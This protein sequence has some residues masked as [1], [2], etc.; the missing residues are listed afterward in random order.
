MDHK[1]TEYRIFKK[2]FNSWELRSL[3]EERFGGS[4]V[5]T[6]YA[7]D[8]TEA[9]LRASAHAILY[10]FKVSGISR[11]NKGHLIKVR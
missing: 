6:I 3:D 1:I 11:V 8:D 9:K 4:W 7:K 2:G 10:S 5:A